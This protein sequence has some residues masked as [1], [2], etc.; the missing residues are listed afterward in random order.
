MVRISHLVR[1]LAACVSKMQAHSTASYVP[2]SDDIQARP[3]ERTVATRYPAGP[4]TLRRGTGRTESRCAY[5]SGVNSRLLTRMLW[6]SEPLGSCMLRVSELGFMCASARLSSL[7]GCFLARDS[8]GHGRIRAWHAAPG[9]H[10][11]SC[12]WDQPRKLALPRPYEQRRRQ[13]AGAHPGDHGSGRW[14]SSSAR[15]GLLRDRQLQVPVHTRSCGDGSDA[16]NQSRL[17][18]R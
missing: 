8:T 7:G 6:C 1:A 10:G 4:L 16:G 2:H 12:G 14:S 9:S 15:K 3:C 13:P 5:D 18:A 17:V 11:R